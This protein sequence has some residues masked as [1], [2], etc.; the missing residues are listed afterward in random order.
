VTYLLVLTGFYVDTEVTPNSTS[1]I[2][3]TLSLLQTGSLAI[4]D[5]AEYT[6][7][8]SLVNGHY[9]SDKAPLPSW[10]F[11]VPIW[12]LETITPSPS[13]K[14]RFD[15]ALGLGGFLFA[16]I[17]LAVFGLWL[18]RDG[19]SLPATSIVLFGT[20][21]WLYSG[22]FFG[23]IFAGFLVVA[24]YRLAFLGRRPLLA[25]LCLG[26][27][28]LSEFPTALAVPA[29]VLAML[30]ETNVDPGW[31]NRLS[32]P[33]VEPVLRLT[34]GFAIVGAIVLPYNASVTGQPFT[35]V[36]SYVSEPAFAPMRNNLGFQWSSIVGGLYGL[37][38]SPSRGLF[39]FAP[40]CLLVFVKGRSWLRGLRKA[41]GIPASV[42]FFF[43][44]L[45]LFSSYYMWAGGWAYGPRHLIPALMLVSAEL[46]SVVGD[47]E[48]DA[49]TWVRR[50][51]LLAFGIVG[52]LPAFAAK[53]TVQYLLP[54]FVVSPLPDVVWPAFR[55]G[56]WNGHA[57]TSMFLGWSPFWSGAYFVLF[58]VAGGIGVQVLSKRAD[59]VSSARSESHS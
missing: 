14:V 30:G 6:Q 59:A 13:L 43:A 10:L 20:L 54:D 3:A 15:R 51:V 38:L 45:L 31:R 5:L 1:R 36:Y 57:V 24:A 33:R 46:A 25:G 18:L 40:I 48:R 4:D 17:P 2:V 49:R 22:T 29:F 37:L 35:M 41:S 8:R 50:G 19:L 39:V 53:L 42:T 44:S 32:W 28:F 7:D 16:S 12:A 52:I 56:R 23:H 21:L 55:D 58:A 27:A 11:T 9:Y 34:I 47:E 26:A